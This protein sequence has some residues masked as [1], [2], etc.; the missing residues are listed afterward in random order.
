MRVRWTAALSRRRFPISVLLAQIHDRLRPATEIFRCICGFALMS[1]AMSAAAP[2]SSWIDHARRLYDLTP[3]SAANPVVASVKDC[4]IEIPLSELRAFVRFDTPPAKRGQTLTTEEKRRE[5]DK[6]LNDHFWVWYGYQHRADEMDPEIRGM[7]KITR[8]E[9]MRTLVIQQEVEA[10]A[11][12]FTEY[13]L[14]K[15]A[16]CRRLFDQADIHISPSSYALLKAA[17]KRVNASDAAGA[18]ANVEKMTLADGLTQPQRLQPLA[19]CRA[20]MVRIGDFL[21]AYTGA[22]VA[23]RADLDDRAAMIGLLAQILEPAL[24]LAAAE[25]RGLDRAVAVRQQVQ[26]DRTGL[27]RQWALESIA[28]Q[29]DAEMH[30]PENAARVA[31]WYAA[32]RADL[33]TARDAAGKL[34]VLEYA[35]GREQVESD[36]FTNLMERGRAEQVRRMRQAHAATL[37]LRAVDDAAI[38]W[39]ELPARLEMPAAKIAWDG[40]TRTYIVK[41]GETRARFIFNLHNVSGDLLTIDDIHPVNE[42]VTVE[43]PALPWKLPPGEQ[44]QVQL[45]VDLRHKYGTGSAPIEV[46]S[47]VGAKTLTLQITYPPRPAAL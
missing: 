39:L 47:S 36:Y 14:L 10:K 18:A 29:A 28:H 6:L 46:E 26:S 32:H 17:A 27:V 8:D 35:A 30:R 13:R 20:G 34:H 11:K 33:Y 31:A 12:T 42:F 19:T 16:F 43:G 25:V 45:E 9:A 40:D 37:D 38:G 24:L 7:L 5:L 3:V 2:D 1:G 41:P 21:A 44:A 23:Q 4:D 22:P 15:K